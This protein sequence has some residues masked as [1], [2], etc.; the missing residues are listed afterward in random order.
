MTVTIELSAEME[1]ALKRIASARGMALPDAITWL[2]ENQLPLPH[3]S[4][5][6]QGRADAWRA[7]TAGLPLGAPLSD[8]AISPRQYLRLAVVTGVLVDTNVLLRRTQPTQRFRFCPL[9]HRRDRPVTE[10][11]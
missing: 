5:S 6:P 9:R 7:S 3:P 4:V 10:T 1:S 11:P 2:L 8:E